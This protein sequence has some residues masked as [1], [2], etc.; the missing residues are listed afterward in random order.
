M[1]GNAHKPLKTKFKN[2]YTFNASV[3]Q[4][5]VIFAELKQAL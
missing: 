5:L 3:A 4:K 2:Q 1:A